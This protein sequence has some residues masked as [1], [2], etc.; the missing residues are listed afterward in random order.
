M[1][2][3]NTNQSMPQGCKYLKLKGDFFITLKYYDQIVPK[4]PTKQK[5]NIFFSPLDSTLPNLVPELV[6]VWLF[7]TILYWHGMG[8]KCV[9]Q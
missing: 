4:S 7:S 5:F 3:N 2:N 1:F 9:L 8:R 6:A